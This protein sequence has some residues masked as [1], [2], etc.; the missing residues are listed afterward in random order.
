MTHKNAALPSSFSQQINGNFIGMLHWS[1]L[2]DLWLKVRT[3]PQGW[4]ASQVG[5]AAPLQ[6]MTTVALNQFIDEVDALLRH[7]HQHNYCGIVYA[8]SPEQ[9]AFI[10]IY[11]PHHLGSFCSH[12]GAVIQPRWVLSRV[13]PERF[14]EDVPL[15]GSRQSWWQRMFA[16]R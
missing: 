15:P 8:D 13:Q 2:D 7:E 3:Q 1:Q 14:E 10:K 6:P 16:S 9:P 5:E 11:D 12:G 4:Y